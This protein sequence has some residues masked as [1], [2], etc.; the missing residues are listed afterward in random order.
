M[1][2]YISSSPQYITTVISSH[3]TYLSNYTTLS[4]IACGTLWLNPARQQLQVWDGSAW[5]D[6]TGSTVTVD[7]SPDVKSLLEWAR[8][9]RDKEREIQRRIT[10]NP[11]LKAAYDNFKKAEEQ[12]KI[13]EIL[14][15]DY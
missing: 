14:S 10:E 15:N 6:Y 8:V 1:I 9:Q 5:H 3:V 2:S 4:G 11:A 7:L 13:T 12:L